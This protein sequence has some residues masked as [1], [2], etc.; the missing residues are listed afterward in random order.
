MAVLIR[1]LV[2]I[3]RRPW[4]LDVLDLLTVNIPQRRKASEGYW[5]LLPERCFSDLLISGKDSS[6]CQVCLGCNKYGS[7]WKI[8]FFILKPLS[9]KHHIQFGWISILYSSATLSLMYFCVWCGKLNQEHVLYPNN[10]PSLFYPPIL[11][12]C[13]FPQQYS[14]C[15]GWDFSI[16][17]CISW[18]RISIGPSL[19]SKVCVGARN[20]VDGP[21]FNPQH[22]FTHSNRVTPWWS[23]IQIW[24][25][26]VF[27]FLR[28]S[29]SV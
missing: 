23:S 3:F 5:T 11:F 10:V 16:Y 1:S 19:Y 14:F 6:Y 22:L 25:Y 13:F 28:Q 15:E 17:W 18:C 26:G 8:T 24:V 29:F 2:F 7:A 20:G 4:P 27:F 21:F 9:D 12:F